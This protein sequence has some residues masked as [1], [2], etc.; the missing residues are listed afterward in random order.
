MMQDALDWYN[1]RTPGG[2]T[3]AADVLTNEVDTQNDRPIWR[4]Y[5][6][7]YTPTGGSG[8][9]YDTIITITAPLN[10]GNAQGKVTHLYIRPMKKVYVDGVETQSLYEDWDVPLPYMD[11]EIYSDAQGNACRTALMNLVSGYPAP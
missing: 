9:G 11:T 6:K 7:R 2:N 5:A 8:N 3:L 10:P 4:F 1:A